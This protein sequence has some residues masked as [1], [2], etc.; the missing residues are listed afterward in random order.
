[1]TINIIDFLKIELYIS[2]IVLVI[3]FIILG[4]KL[5]KTFTKFDG[6]LNDINDKMNR[7]DSAF[8]IV[9]KTADYIDSISNS[10]SNVVLKLV[11]KFLK[12][13]GNDTSEE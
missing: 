13:K 4:I 11:R 1:M 10:I 9:G 3:V 5:I 8:E 6:L 12:K 7:V 2:L